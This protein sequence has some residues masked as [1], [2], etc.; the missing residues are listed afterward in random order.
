M[1]RRLLCLFLAVCCWGSC[2]RP[3]QEVEPND[4]AAHANPLS[5][6]GSI[7]GTISSPD[8]VDWYKITIP[9]DSGILN[10]HV[11][12]IKTADFVLSFRDKDLQEL[13]R[14][15]ETGVGGDEEALDLGVTRGE[16]YVVLSNKNPKADNPTQKYLLSASLESDAGREREPNDTALTASPLVVNGVTRGHYYPTTNP[17]YLEG[18]KGEEDWFHLDADRPGNFILNLDLSGVPGVAPVLEVYDAND[19]KLKEL[20]AG[21]GEGL[22]L[23]DFGVHAPQKLLFR[24]H[25]RGQR[26]GNPDVFYEILTELLPDNGATESEPNDQRQDATPFVKD[27]IT[28]FIAPAGDVDWFRINPA[29]GTKQILRA[30]LSAVPGMDLVLR[31]ADELGKPLVRVDNAGMEAPESLTGLGLSNATYYLIVSEKTGKLS[32]TRHAYTLT[33][34]LTPWQPGLEWEPNDTPETAQAVKVGESVDGYLAPKGDVDFYE[35][36]VYQ[37]SSILIDLTGLLNV[38]WSVEL[39]N[40]DGRSIQS[41]AAAKPGEGVAF[42]RVL[43][44]GTYQLKLEG[45][46]PSQNNVR[47][48]YT[49]RIRAR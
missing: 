25:T 33:K 23:K 5:P 28:G 15:D 1:I 35:F 46:D 22:S 34:S 6:N 48:K 30:D 41:L 11:T 37:K 20:S 9:R 19:Y 44:T 14:I 13:K 36:N 7:E 38:R 17:L 40:Q 49:L 21:V 27:A 39:F 32:D 10:L 16:Y 43:E 29:T 42:E 45:T 3:S 26:M 18:N 8:D 4:D 47:D 31:V 12:G 24:L 2:R